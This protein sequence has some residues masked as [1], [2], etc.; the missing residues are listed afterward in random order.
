MNKQPRAPM[1]RSKN[2]SC[3]LRDRTQVFRIGHKCLYLL[4]HLRGLNIGRDGANQLL[5]R[6]G[7]G[8]P[9]SGIRPCAPV[10]DAGSSRCDQVLLQ[11]LWAQANSSLGLWRM[12]RDV[13]TQ[14]SDISPVFCSPSLPILEEKAHDQARHHGGARFYDEG[15]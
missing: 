13:S 4:S 2:N 10:T 6:P 11:Q 12:G 1:Q 9:G 15:S 8:E 7:Q 5:K 3:E 14:A